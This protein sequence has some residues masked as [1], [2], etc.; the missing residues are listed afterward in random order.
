MR[1]RV[2]AECCRQVLVTR[3]RQ[4]LG[5][6][7]CQHCRRLT[8]LQLDIAT[9]HLITD[10]VV[11]DVDVLRTSMVDGVLCHLDA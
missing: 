4:S 3:S 1:T 11:L 8:L 5:H 6:D 9:L 7:V 10:V 2:Y